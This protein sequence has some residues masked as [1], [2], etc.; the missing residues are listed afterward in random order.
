MHDM[1]IRGG[2]IVDGSGRPAFVGDVAVD[3][4]LI[5]AVGIVTQAGREEIDATGLHV[6]PGFVDI[7][8]HYDGQATWDSEMAPSAW[9]GVTTVVMGNCGVGFAP[10][11]PN[12]HQWLIGLMEGVE[13]IPGTALAEGMAWNWESFPEYL[14]ALEARPRTIDVATH[15]PHGAVRAYVMGERGANNEAPTEHEIAQ[16]S[17]IVEEGLRAGALGFSTSRTVLH[18]SVDGVLV[19]GTTATKEELIGIG[20]AM[21]R[22]GHGVFEMASDLKYEWDEFGWMGELSRETGLPV[23]YA[24]LQSIA[25][26][27]TWQEQMAATAEWNAKG[28]NIVAQIALRGTGILMAW[29]GT[30]HPFLFKPGWQEIAALPWDEQ[31]ARLRDPEFKARML[32]EAPVFPESD[33]LPLLHAV[34]MGF[35]L[36]FAMEP[37]FDY[38]PPQSRTIAA[39]AASAGRDPADYAYDLLMEGDGTGFI[40]FPILNYADGNLDFVKGL[41]ERD[42]TVI[43]LSD[44]GAHCGTICDAASPTYLLQHWVRDRARGTITLEQAIKR[45]CSDTARLYGM[46]DRGRIAPGYR[47]DLNVIDMGALKLGAPWMAFDLPAGGKRLLQRAEGYRLTIKNGE[48][49]FRDGVPTGALPGG[50]VRGPQA[51]PALALAAE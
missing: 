29:R 4:G 44:G 38:E 10:A 23:T 3:K 21:G 18:K 8:T 48:V 24:M 34:A 49:T 22:A 28:A 7:H 1:V 37:G 41:L 50:L 35:G 46:H 31:L 27:M 16:M 45:Q 51:A 9:H 17:R 25:K 11:K 30:V 14:D 47:A 6:T 40:Y 2:T 19:P 26:E 33:V 5:S 13:D 43:S 20:R 15:V 42:D 12:K 39:L 32:A 36:Q